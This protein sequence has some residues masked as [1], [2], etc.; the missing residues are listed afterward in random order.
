MWKLLF[1]SFLDGALPPFIP[2]SFLNSLCLFLCI[3]NPKQLFQPADVYFL[4][5]L[6][7]QIRI[8]WTRVQK[9]TAHI[10]S[11]TGEDEE[12]T[13]VLLREVHQCRYLL[14]R[15]KS[16]LPPAAVLLLFHLFLTL[17]IPICFPLSYLSSFLR[18]MWECDHRVSELFH[19]SSHIYACGFSTC[20]FLGFLESRHICGETKWPRAGAFPPGSSQRGKNRKVFFGKWN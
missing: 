17:F 6:M 3:T 20:L 14:S 4:S 19:T 2:H 16:S 10:L 5:G 7:K 18:S 13:F 1:S 12:R 11:L 8:R 15:H 9:Y